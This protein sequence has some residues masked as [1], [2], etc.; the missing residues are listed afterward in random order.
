[1]N[2][3]VDAASSQVDAADEDT[4]RIDAA[5][6]AELRGLRAKR[7]M[8]QQALADAANMNK[9]TVQRLESGERPM[10]M[11]Q[12]YRFCRVLGVKPSQLVNA[13]ETEVGIE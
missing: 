12:L 8:T 1:M 10:T 7:G 9:K 2:E 3:T 6:G 4:K 11:S 13:M 5:L